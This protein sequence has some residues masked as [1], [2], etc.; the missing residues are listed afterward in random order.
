ME[1]VPI[2]N[3]ST[4][5]P[6]L[7]RGVQPSKRLCRKLFGPVDHEEIAQILDSELDRDA[8]EKSEEWCFNFSE[9]TPL[10]N[11]RLVW[12]EVKQ[13][14]KD[15]LSTKSEEKVNEERRVPGLHGETESSDNDVFNVSKDDSVASTTQFKKSAAPAACSKSVNEMA[16]PS[17]ANRKRKKQY[18]TITGKCL[19]NFLV[20][21]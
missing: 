21:F 4:T 15:E 6:P 16:S 7:T 2:R 1:A 20:S 13:R 9:G 11:G 10:N 12:E 14:K 5:L 19:K 8:K 3:C 18:K 17:T